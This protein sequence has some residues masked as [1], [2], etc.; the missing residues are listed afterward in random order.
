MSDLYFSSGVAVYASRG[1][2]V[3]ARGMTG[4]IRSIRTAARVRAERDKYVSLWARVLESKTAKED[5]AALKSWRKSMESAIK[6]FRTQ[7]F[8]FAES[9]LLAAKKMAG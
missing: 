3:V 7:G 4:V 6:E 2:L 5:S 9:A 1:A 8:S